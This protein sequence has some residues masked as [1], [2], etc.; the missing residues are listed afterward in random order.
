MLSSTSSRVVGLGNGSTT[1]WPFSFQ[2]NQLAD[3]V[4]TYTD[5]SGNSTVLSSAQFTVTGLGNAAG[6]TVTYPTSGS[7]IATGTTLTIQRIVSPTQPTQVSNQGAMWPAIIEAAMDR[8][9][10]ICQGFLDTASRALTIPATDSITLNPLPSATARANS[11]LAFDGSG[12]PI[13]TTGAASGTTVSVAM[14]PVVQASTLALGRT[15]LGAAGLADN[16]TLTGSNDF[17]GGSIVVPTQSA[18]DNSTKAA[19]TAMVQAAITANVI[20]SYLAGLTLSNDVGTP[21]T[22]LDV[23]GGSCT[24]DTNAVMLVLSAGTIDCTTVG[25]NGLDA[26]SLGTSTWYHVYAISKAAGASTAFLASTSASSPTLPATYTLKRRIGSFK[27]DGSAHILAFYQSGDT[28]LW[29][30]PVLDVN[31]TLGTGARTFYNVTVPPNQRVIGKFG[32]TANGSPSGSNAS[33]L[34]TNNDIADTAPAAPGLG[35]VF[36]TNSGAMGTAMDFPVAPSGTS[37]AAQIALR[38]TLSVSLQVTTFGWIDR[39]GRDA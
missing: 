3:M 13:A 21:N 39:R 28:F 10:M 17:T 11:Y 12:Q 25:A 2:V 15:A 23:A 35:N 7:P 37:G 5:A 24:D 31:G 4:V 29:G 18:S 1:A 34:V 33:L 27:T 9:V 6:G 8:I 19:S 14:A 36:T 16:N 20:R 32:I 38:T 30:T 26:G 22:K